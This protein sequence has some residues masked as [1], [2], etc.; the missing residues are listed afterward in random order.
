MP[1]RFVGE[2]PDRRRS[3]IQDVGKGIK[4]LVRA[5]GKNP[6]R[7]AGH[8]LRRGGDTVDFR[9]GAP[10]HNIQLE[11]CGVA[12]QSSTTTKLMRLELPTR[13]TAA[14][15]VTRLGGRIDSR[16]TS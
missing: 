2:R 10:V 16:A 12:T 9:L 5:T 1:P 6:T 7:F 15:Y 4:E 3:T 8:S 14:V 13:M 11:G